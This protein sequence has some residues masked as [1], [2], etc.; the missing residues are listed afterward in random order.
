MEL[1][2]DLM[3]NSGE[4]GLIIPNNILLQK[5]GRKL[6]ELLLKETTI[7]TIID[8]GYDAFEDA[9]VPTTVITYSNTISQKNKVKF[10]FRPKRTD[11]DILFE[12]CN[13]DEFIENQF[14]AFNIQITPTE[15]ALMKKMEKVGVPLKELCE[16]KIGI[17]CKP[18]YIN[19]SPISD[20]SKP[21]VRGRNFHKY[22]LDFESDPKYVEYDKKLLH[23]AREERLF[24]CPKK[25]IIRQTG[26]RIIGTIDT[27]RLYAWKSVFVIV[28]TDK[29]V[30]LEYLLALLNSSTINFYYQKIVGERGRAFAQVK[31]VNLN[32]IPLKIGNEKEQELINAEI[33]K[34]LIAGSKLKESDKKFRNYLIKSTSILLTRKLDN[35]FDLDFT[36]FISELNKAFKKIKR[37]SLT[38]MEEME[39]L[40]IF[41][42][43]KTETNAFKTELS[44]IENRIDKLVTELYE[45]T[46]KEIELVE[47]ANA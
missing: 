33:D 17:E 15:K 21:M 20:I 2:L 13:Q 22:R 14:F 44:K 38:K 37:D 28:P 24:D 40:E 19:E 9:V 11:F 31:G 29:K 42:N 18:N 10:L 8:V 43:N 23:R 25:I 26:D 7:N 47:N 34:A 45:L 39:W 32:P 35:W 1:S 27:S 12:E 5:F 41:E 46:E 16:L 6:R 4:C 30:S 36:D 3:K